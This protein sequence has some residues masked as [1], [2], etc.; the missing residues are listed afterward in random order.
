M[1]FCCKNS[2]LLTKKRN[3]WLKSATKKFKGKTRLTRKDAFWRRK[4]SLSEKRRPKQN[5][6]AKP[7]K[8]LA[9]LK[10]R[11]RKL[12]SRASLLAATNP[13]Q[14]LARVLLQPQ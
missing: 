5:A 8:N 10:K 11:N 9:R 12:L 3:A 14:W 7:M 4:K 1:K 2:K 13:V 6:S